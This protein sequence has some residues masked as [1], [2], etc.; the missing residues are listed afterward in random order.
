MRYALVKAG[1]NK[2]GKVAADG[3]GEYYYGFFLID[4]NGDKGPN[5]A[6]ADT[7]NYKDITD[8]FE[9]TMFANRVIAGGPNY[10]GSADTTCQKVTR[11]VMFDK[12]AKK[13]NAQ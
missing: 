3:E 7:T 1:A 2:I 10:D 8:T 9:A 11:A 6:N 12:K 4:V 13:L 5:R